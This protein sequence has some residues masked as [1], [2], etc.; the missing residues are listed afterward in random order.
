ML[1]DRP[2]RRSPG[3]TD[4]LFSMVALPAA[5]ILREYRR[6]GSD[7]LPLTTGMLRAKG[8]FPLLNWYTE[9]L[10]KPDELLHP[11][12]VDRW[13]PGIDFN[14]AVQLEIIGGFKATDELV[15][16]AWT[17]PPDVPNAFRI[18]NRYYDGGDADF[19]YQML[20]WLKPRRLIEVGAGHSTKIA[21]LA[22]E[23]NAAETG[24]VTEHRCIEPFEVDRLAGW[25]GFELIRERVE[26]VKLDWSKELS[27]GD[28]LFIDSSHMIR[29]QGDVVVE[30]LEILPQLAPGVIVHFHDIHTPRDVP[31]QWLEVDVRFWNEQY[32][33]E[34]L[35][36]DSPRYEIVAALNYLR[37]HHYDVLASV[38]P[39]LNQQTEPSSFYLRIR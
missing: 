19:F 38:C 17:S 39:Y 32:L 34:A 13:L 25:S 33:L 28:V 31:A 14:D 2:Y 15:S 4:R 10:F 20:R 8:V 29:P 1:M 23:R 27:A 5:L 11:L 26:N 7:R 12:D 30:L 16:M 21:R 37:H 9:P 22:L 6:F 36:S 24:V 18:H 3:L 35:L